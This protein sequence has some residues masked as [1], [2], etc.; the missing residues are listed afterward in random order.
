PDGVDG[1]PEVQFDGQSKTLVINFGLPRLE[2][3]PKVIEYKYVA[4]RKQ[5]KPVEMKPKEF[6]AF[7]DDVIHQIALRTIHEAFKTDLAFIDAVVFNGWVQGIDSKTGK[8]FISCILSCRASRQQFMGLDLAL[9][10]PKECVR[11][12]KGITAGPLAMLAP[13]KPI[14]E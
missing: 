10:S 12:L 4:S 8:P 11:G 7:Y 1:D 2:D 9:V 6:D 5:V 14:M 13:V 3:V